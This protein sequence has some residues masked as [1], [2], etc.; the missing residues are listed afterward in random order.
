M[1]RRHPICR[2]GFSEA[3]SW[4][5]WYTEQVSE[6]QHGGS[7]SL[8][9]MWQWWAGGELSNVTGTDG[10]LEGGR[11]QGWSFQESLTH[12]I[13]TLHSVIIV[14]FFVEMATRRYLIDLR[15][16]RTVLQRRNSSCL[17]LFTLFFSSFFHIK[18]PRRKKDKLP[19]ISTPPPTKNESHKYWI[20][21]N[22]WLVNLP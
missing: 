4:N 18:I 20:S 8:M 2:L 7:T 15:W 12:N 13:Q 19:P 16:K 10:L 3:D 22:I 9:C 11:T 6:E 14:I 17:L 21:K 1:F 5:P